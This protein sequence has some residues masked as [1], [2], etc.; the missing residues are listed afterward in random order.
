MA[1]FV[2]F[3]Q[4]VKQLTKPNI[5]RSTILSLD[6]NFV[7]SAVHKLCRYIAVARK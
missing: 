1:E 6:I 5:E 3:I 7:L 2:Y 4:G